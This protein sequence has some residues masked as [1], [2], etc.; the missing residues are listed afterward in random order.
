MVLP[1]LSVFFEFFK[2]LE[3]NSSTFIATMPATNKEKKGES[4]RA[5]QE[6]AL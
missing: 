3:E 4:E 6:D 5:P 1:A 2:K